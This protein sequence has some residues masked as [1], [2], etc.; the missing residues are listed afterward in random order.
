MA[1]E[2]DL[3]AVGCGDAIDDADERCLAC[4]VRAQ[5]TENLSAGH[6]NAHVIECRVV[7]K[8]LHD[9]MG[10]QEKSSIVVSILVWVNYWDDEWR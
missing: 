6:V 3:T 7:G 8:A 4:P 1:V 10:A 5:Q 9:V 2:D